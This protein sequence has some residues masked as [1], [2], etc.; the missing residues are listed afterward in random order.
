M[1]QK[2]PLL[3]CLLIALSGTTSLRSQ[4]FYSNGATVAVTPGGVLY[5][6]GGITLDNTT[7]LTNNGSITTTKNSTFLLPGT[8]T[9]NNSSS[10]QGNGTYQVEQDW[11]NNATFVG[12]NSTVRMFGNTQQFITSVNNTVTSFN[13]LTLLGNGVGNNRK[14]TLQL[15]NAIS[16]PTGVDSLND[17]E[18]ETQTNIFFVQNTATTSVQNNQTPGSEGFVSSLNPGTFSRATAVGGGSYYFPTGSSVV[19]TRYR[20]VILDNTAAVTTD[21]YHVRFINWNPD[22]D[23]F[24]RSQ[25]DGLICLAND[26]FYHAIDRAAGADPAT[27]TLHYIPASDGNWSGMSHWRN[28]STNWNDMSTV[29]FGASGVFTTMTRTNWLFATAGFPYVLTAVH[30]TAPSIVCPSVCQNSAN[31][32]F[33]ATTS[34]TGNYVWSVPGNGTIV[35]GQGTDSLS[36]NWTSGS[37]YVS[38]Y[39]LDPTTNCPSLAD[40]CQP[41]LLPSPF[42]NFDTTSSGPWLNTY[43]FNDLSTNTSTWSWNFGDGNTS[44]QESPSHGYSSSG[45][46]TVTLIATSGQGCLDTMTQ[47]VTV[48]E[49]VLIPNV[50]SPNG[51]G[52]NDE[53]YIPSSGFKEYKIEIYDRWG[54]KVFESESAE[55][56]WDGRSTSGLPCTDGTY[57]YILHALTNTKDYSQTGFLTLIGSKK[58]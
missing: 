6:N 29:S 57:Y 50:F 47:I 7:A 40:S 58:Q 42:A 44:T 2:Y 55:I 41:T 35:S 56:H 1:K 34:G 24:L 31:N 18:L 22:N 23:G 28:A 36:V 4:I 52:N 30:P 33:T 13:N 9:I 8:F 39:I 45:T 48:L 11:I 19:L 21:E 14:K 43:S 27:I 5:C 54:V 53:F 49:G 17:R 25:N 51:D 26:T 10:S 46:Y 20:P 3:F 15:V 38:V 32:I 37:G 12:N 16:G